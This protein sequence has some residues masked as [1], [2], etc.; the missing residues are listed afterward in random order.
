MEVFGTGGELTCPAGP[1]FLD[2]A[3]TSMRLLAAV[4]CLAK[5]TCMLTGNERMRSRPVGELLDGLKPLGGVLESLRRNGCPPV[6][7]DGCGLKGAVHYGNAR[8]RVRERTIYYR[9]AAGRR[10][11]TR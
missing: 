5:G 7:V 10:G 6:R 9:P 1:I 11:Y 2:N 8:C 3:G 4:A